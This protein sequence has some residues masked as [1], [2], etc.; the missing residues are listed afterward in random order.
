MTD[1]DSSTDNHH[2]PDLLAVEETDAY[3]L[4]LRLAK[5]QMECVAAIEFKSLPPATPR[6]EPPRSESNNDNLKLPE[7]ETADTAKGATTTVA[8]PFAG[9]ISLKTSRLIHLLQQHQVSGN[10]DEDAV[11][12]FCATVDLQ[13]EPQPTVVARGIDPQTGADGW[14]ELL[15]KISGE[16]QEFIPDSKG[17]VDLKRLNAYTEIEPEQKLGVIHPPE[18]GISGYTVQ[19]LEIEGPAGSPKIINA[20]EGVVL[21]YDGRMA[22]STRAGRALF[23]NNTL[24][25]VDQLVIPGNV[26]LHVGHIDFN[27][28]VEIK[29][30]VLDDFDVRSTKGIKI[31]GHVGACH[32][33]SQGSIDVGAMA[34]REIGHIFCQGD[35]HT[36]YLNQVTV[37]CYGD[38]VVTNE[39]RNSHV[40]ATGHIVVARGGIIGGEVLA[41][42]GVS[43]VTIGA[44]SGQR[45][46]VTA[47]VYF[48]D[49]ER[50]EYISRQL[51]SVEQ[52]ITAING[53][54]RPLM[55]HLRKGSQLIDTARARLQIL[56]DKLD[57]LYQ[58]KN[59]FAAEA[60]TSQ[61]LEVEDKN[62]KINVQQVLRDGVVIALGKVKEEIKLDRQGPLSI[63]ENARDGGLRFL[64][65]TALSVPA[66]ELER[67]Q[68]DHE[69]DS[70]V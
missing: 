24:T 67:E 2:D 51:H 49:A 31:N 4:T 14:F 29:G 65:L 62:P 30:D 15:V 58:Q 64:S 39:V 40:R 66:T 19:G 22:F 26:D 47:G 1:Q 28:F 33:E 21:K 9:G 20:G 38:V 44:V 63:I 6:Q 17:R 46:R 69:A 25:V 52:Q 60:T 18:P 50:S 61:P 53:A 70:N 10:I 7:H 48:P 37:V 36:R 8:D 11:K 59:A 3:R 68:S 55:Q 54:I 16:E 45:T 57:A 5:E 43:A 12:E 23:D 35:L 41:L 13:Q 56:N 32:I 34:G 27:G 42:K